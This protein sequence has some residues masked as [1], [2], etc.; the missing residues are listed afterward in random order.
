MT[1]S[2]TKRNEPHGNVTT[3]PTRLG[4]VIR[5]ALER[6][7]RQQSWL[8]R[9][10]EVPDTRVSEWIRGAR[11]PSSTHLVA[12]AKVLGVP[13]AKL[14]AALGGRNRDGTRRT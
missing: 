14:A 4:K 5:D 9:H 7:D 8:A 2:A 1:M 3:T 10:V 13:L 12:M 6:L 11:E